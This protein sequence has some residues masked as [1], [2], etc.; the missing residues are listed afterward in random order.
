MLPYLTF[1]IT[2][3]F[4]SA[5]QPGPLLTYL[6]S[7]AVTNGWRRT[8]PAALSPVISDI[9][10]VLLVLFLLIRLPVRFEQILQCAGGV[11]LLYLAGSAFTTWRTGQESHAVVVTSVR[12]SMLKATFVNLLNPGPYLGWSLVMGPLFLKGWRE[13]PSYGFGLVVAFYATMVSTL[14]GIIVLFGTARN[15]GPRLSRLLIGLSAI[16]LALF[17]CWRIWT[18][19]Q[20]LLTVN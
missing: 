10:V 1:G 6:I 4:A 11:F 20:A 14:G 18:G 19:V 3:A 2:Y 7:Q 13:S 8:L 9:P 5:V 15:L 12:Q 17:G 16:A